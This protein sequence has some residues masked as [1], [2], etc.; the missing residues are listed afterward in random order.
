MGSKLKNVRVGSDP[1]AFLMNDKGEIVSSIGIVKG[2]KREP[3]DIGNDCGIQTD[4]ILVEYTFP[5]VLLNEVDKFF[6]Y[7]Q[8]CIKYT[9]EYLKNKKI[10]VKIQSSGEAD[11]KYLQHPQ[12]REAG[13]D[14]DFN[15]WTKSTNIPA[16][17]DTTNIRAAGCHIH[18]GYDNP[19][20][21]MSEEIVKALDLFLGVP[22]LFIDKDTER[23]KLYGR[24]GTFRFK[25][26]GVEYRVLGGFTIQDK[27]TIQ[28][29]FN[30]VKQAVD[31][32]NM[33]GSA[34]NEMKNLIEAI[35][36]NNTEIAKMLSE[37]YNLQISLNNKICVDF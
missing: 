16:P 10:T 22:S 21:E 6:N 4:N 5:A 18:I 31:F 25:R 17:Y 7:V 8:Y 33:G 24:A 11:E 9:N 30:C 2:N 29:L 19:N 3:Y 26:Y 12:A 28:W 37:K 1:E 36:N 20:E 13:C 27:E 15:V 14:P 23:R 32:I 34:D 35:N